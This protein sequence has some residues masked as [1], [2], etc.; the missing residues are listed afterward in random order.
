MNLDKL[1]TFFCT[2]IL[3]LTALKQEREAT[4]VGWD[5]TETGGWVKTIESVRCTGWRAWTPIWTSGHRVTIALRRLRILDNR[6]FCTMLDAQ[7][8]GWV[9]ATGRKCDEAVSERTERAATY[10]RRNWSLLQGE[11]HDDQ[12]EAWETQMR[13]WADMDQ[14]AE[15]D[16]ETR[17]GV[18]TDR[19]FYCESCGHFNAARN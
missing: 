9:R 3:R 2:L 4:M 12:Q 11:Y 17:W 13:V 19:G 7:V 14:L 16:I 18:A 6:N 8:N 5:A 1:F 10:L 15:R